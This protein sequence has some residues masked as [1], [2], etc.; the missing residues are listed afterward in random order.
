MT[1]VD[2][3]KIFI[4]FIPLL[5]VFLLNKI[6]CSLQTYLTSTGCVTLLKLKQLATKLLKQNSNRHKRIEL[7]AKS[8]KKVRNC[9]RH[10][11][12]TTSAKILTACRRVCLTRV[13]HWMTQIVLKIAKL[14]QLIG[15]APILKIARAYGLRPRL[16]LLIGLYGNIETDSLRSSEVNLRLSQSNK[17]FTVTDVFSQKGCQAL[18]R[19]I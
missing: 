8:I 9:G 11:P 14:S 10:F 6:V 15:T 5:T 7:W 3:G 2:E 4:L 17:T 19:V 1:T 12:S 16:W 13:P 18:R